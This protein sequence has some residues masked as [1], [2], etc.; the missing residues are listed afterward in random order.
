MAVVGA[1]ALGLSCA[2][3]LAQGGARVTVWDD[4]G[5]GASASA[6][7]AGMVAPASEAWLEPELRADP[8]LLR[9][10][11]VRWT[12]FA[13]ELGVA[14]AQAGA[15]HLAPRAE[16]DRREAELRRLGFAP[17]RLTSKEALHLAPALAC[18]PRHGA[19]FAPEDAALD[20]PRALAALRAALEA[21][22]GRVR[23]GRVE[24][25]PDGVRAGGG[26]LACDALVLAGGAP[27][28]S[29]R[30]APELAMLRPV[31]GQLLRFEAG[32]ADPLRHPML[33]GEGAYLAAQSSGW[34][35]GA[36]MEP[37]RDDLELDPDALAGLRRAAAALVPHLATAPA[38]G[39]AGVRASTPDG[40]PLAGPSAAPGVWLATG[41]RRN[42]WLFAPLIAEVVAESVLARSPAPELASARRRLHPGRPGLHFAGDG[43]GR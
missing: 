29:D 20:A 24:A 22:G 36:T 43:E 12:G 3:R 39:R 4:E 25:G 40:W 8:D 1:G 21:Q 28:R 33:R 41:A 18:E 6:V 37:G 27:G 19:L 14:L 26:L 35:A 7:A 5:G 9:A 10:A 13:A 34:A 11:R 16:L 15:V 30:L 23:A 38:R 32:P 17:R 42:G 2:L 31:K